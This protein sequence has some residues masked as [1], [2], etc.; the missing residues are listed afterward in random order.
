MTTGWQAQ[1]RP[2]HL[3]QQCR[4]GS[5]AALPAARSCYGAVKMCYPPARRCPPEREWPH[6]QLQVSVGGEG[7]VPATVHTA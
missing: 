4:L 5:I 6:C 2:H 7:Q 1:L 3:A